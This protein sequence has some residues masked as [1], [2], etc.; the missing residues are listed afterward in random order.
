[1]HLNNSFTVLEEWNSPYINHFIQPDTIIAEQYSAQSWD[2]YSY[3]GNNPLRYTDPTGHMA[4]EG[5]GDEGKNHCV[6]SAEEEMRNLQHIAKLAHEKYERKCAAGDNAYCNGDTGEIAAFALTMWTG[7]TAAESFILGG[8]LA[9]GG[10][11]AYSAVKP[12]LMPVYAWLSNFFTHN[13]DSQTVSLGSYDPAELNG[14]IEMANQ[15]GNMYTYFS[16]HPA[17]YSFLD[18]LGLA[19][20]I[21]EGFMVNQMAQGKNFVVT[22][23]GKFPGPGTLTE[24]EMLASDGY[25]RVTSGLANF[26]AMFMTGN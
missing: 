2:R 1:L 13:P 21:N 6:A 12:A 7:G 15:P 9:D 23:L 14:Y 25:G 20:P 16:M 17:L 11:A 10:A 18:K 3:V 22:V 24:M 5:C 8:G 4:V 19:N 26:Y